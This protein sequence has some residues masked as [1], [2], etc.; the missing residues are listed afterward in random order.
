MSVELETLDSN[1]NNCKHLT[2]DVERFD[3]SVRFHHQLSLNE[4]E[5]TR[6]NLLLIADGYYKKQEFEKGFQVEKEANKMK[7]QFSKKDECPINYGSC[8]K[9]QKPVSF[10]PGI[11][12]LET[13]D[14]FEHRK[15]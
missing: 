15:A 10:I 4:F 13:Q 8:L 12:Q 11:C 6:T 2:R 7:F 1:C 3:E 9:F 5:T 14:C